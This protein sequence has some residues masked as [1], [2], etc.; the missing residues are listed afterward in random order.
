MATL[1]L[2]R[3]DE[4]WDEALE[5]YFAFHKEQGNICDE[6]SKVDSEEKNGIVF[7]RNTNGLLA[8]YGTAQKKI[9]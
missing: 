7:L 6:P 8:R 2:D 4:F 3:L 5:A 1:T 9:F